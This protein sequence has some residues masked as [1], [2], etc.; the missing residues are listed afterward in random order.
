MRFNEHIEF[1]IGPQGTE[2]YKGSNHAAGYD[3]HAAEDAR[4]NP[5]L[6][7]VVTTDLKVLLPYGSFAK[8]ETW[9]SMAIKGLQVQGGIIDWDYCGE[10]KVMI[11]NLTDYP[12]YINAGD[13]ITQMI[14]HQVGHPSI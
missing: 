13:R 7:I 6:T 1:T 10:L 14:L 8:L 3:I 12:Y 5:H 2:P 4:I 11:H 9:S